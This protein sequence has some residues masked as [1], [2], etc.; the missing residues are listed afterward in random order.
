[1]S[2]RLTQNAN[3]CQHERRTCFCEAGLSYGVIQLECIDP[4]FADQPKPSRWVQL[5]RFTVAVQHCLRGRGLGCCLLLTF[6]H[7]FNSTAWL[8]KVNTTCAPSF[9]RPRPSRHASCGWTRL[10]R[11][12]PGARA[13]AQRMEAHRRGCWARSFPGC[14][15]RWRRCSW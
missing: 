14:R 10:R 7:T 6:P 9:K 12:W 15:K 2:Q 8:V 11:E 5:R 1:M 3:L 13:V 4:Q